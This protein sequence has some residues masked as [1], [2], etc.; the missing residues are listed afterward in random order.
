MAEIEKYR[1]YTH[2][3]DLDKLYALYE[4]IKKR[5]NYR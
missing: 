1:V 5:S 2:I 3:Q 4:N